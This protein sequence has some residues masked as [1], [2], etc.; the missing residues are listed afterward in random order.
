[1]HDTART[2]DSQHTDLR[3]AAKAAREAK[4]L[5]AIARDDDVYTALDRI[6]S[7]EVT[8]FHC[9]TCNRWTFARPPRCAAA[10][11]IIRPGKATKRYYRC[12]RCAFSLGYLESNG[13]PYKVSCPR[14][15]ATGEWEHGTAA[16]RRKERAV[17]Q[18]GDAVPDIVET[19]EGGGAQGPLREDDE[20]VNA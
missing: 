19:S 12:K 1:L 6:E 7:V 5:E 17:D 14:C 9:Q 3:D 10:A 13:T 15:N 11:H 20:D 18:H 4:R 16:Q 2:A 8:A